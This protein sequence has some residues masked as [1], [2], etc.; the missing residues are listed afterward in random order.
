M[1]VSEKVGTV[2]LVLH[3]W[4]RKSQFNLGHL[5]IVIA[6]LVHTWLF[7]LTLWSS[8]ITLKGQFTSNYDHVFH[9]RTTD[10]HRMK[11]TTISLNLISSGNYSETLGII[12][13]VYY[14]A[15]AMLLNQ[16]CKD[17]L[18][19]T[20]LKVNKKCT[21]YWWSYWYWGLTHTIHS[22]LQFSWF[23]EIEQTNSSDFSGLKPF[24]L[25]ARNRNFTSSLCL[26][27][28]L[29]WMQFE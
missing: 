21:K 1:Q 19:L 27:L 9:L 11:T 22:Y 29:F 24:G 28:R 8:Q 2:F 5:N 13:S 18:M 14:E 12:F 23:F 3:D 17:F 7:F 4:V 6:G 26:L 15:K 20:D 16:S 25:I 10:S